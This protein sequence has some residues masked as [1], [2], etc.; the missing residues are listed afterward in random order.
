MNI[1]EIKKALITDGDYT[2]AEVEAMDTAEIIA[3]WMAL[4]L[5][6]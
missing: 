1:N 4:P 3:A 6:K 2:A 5:M